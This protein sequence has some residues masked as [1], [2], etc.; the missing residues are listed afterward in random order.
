MS[1][2]IDIHCHSSSKPFMSGIGNPKQNLFSSFNFRLEHKVYKLLRKPIE[3]LSHIKLATQSNLDALFEGGVRVAFVSLT[4]ME[5]AFT[6]LNPN[7]KGTKNELLRTFLA[8]KSNYRNGFLS[9]MAINALTGYK[10]SDIDYIKNSAYDIYTDLFLKE[11]EI[12]AAMDNT[13]SPNGKY[14][15]KFPSSHTELI[16]N[17]NEPNTLNILLNVEGAHVFGKAATLPEIQSGIHQTHQTDHHN[18]AL[19][20]A[21]CLNIKHIRTQYAIPIFSVGLCHHFWNGLA[22][23]A[24][25]LASLLEAILNQDEGLNGPLTDNGRVVIEEFNKREYDGKSVSKIVVDIKHM[26]PQCRKDYYA[27]LSSKPSLKQNPVF[28]SHTGISMSFETLDEWIAYVKQNPQEKSGK[29]YEEGSYY[30]HEQSINLCRE[31][32]VKVYQSK[33]LIGIQLDEKRIMGPLAFQELA[34]RGKTVGS[35][36]KK[37]IYAKAIWANIF[38]AVDEIK[39]SGVKLTNSIWDIFAIGSDFDGLINHLDAFES[40]AKM[41]DLKAA[42]NYFLQEPEDITLYNNGKLARYDIKVED[43]ALLKENFSNHELTEKIFSENAMNFL[44]KI[45]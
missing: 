27:Y 5:K 1:F 7:V 2:N 34:Q 35:S 29:H 24:R 6:V 14:I 19:A 23:H 21:L 45:F 20:N 17:L 44:A 36:E 30:L 25:S 22:G 40:A 39:S 43:M 32:L 16:T 15:V 11:F 28:C 9:S 3:K 41:H 42:M 4:P 38:C 31:D 18:V 33:G 12:L 26:S 37:Y 8:E 10:V 13:T